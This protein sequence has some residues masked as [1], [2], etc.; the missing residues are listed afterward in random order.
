MTGHGAM[1]DGY[2]YGFAPAR[3]VPTPPGPIRQIV[4]AEGWFAVELR[5]AGER[6]VPLLGWALVEPYFPPYRNGNEPA[7]PKTTASV[8]GLIAGKG[9]PVQVV[10]ELSAL[11]GGYRQA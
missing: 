4:A 2:D 3:T 11:F 8:R 10:D 6:L 5:S 7:P 1:I 9:E